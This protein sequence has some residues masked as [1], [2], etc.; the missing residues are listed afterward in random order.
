[1]K[2]PARLDDVP[3]DNY[4]PAHADLELTLAPLPPPSGL[5]RVLSP[6]SSTSL[7]RATYTTP[8]QHAAPNRA[9]HPR[10]LPIAGGAFPPSAPPPRPSPAPLG[11]AIPEARAPRPATVTTVSPRPINRAPI[12]QPEPEAARPVS[13][14]VP[15]GEGVLCMWGG[16][17]GGGGESIKCVCVTAVLVILTRRRLRW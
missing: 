13:G 1:V 15:S 3:L 8:S 7:P 4:L 11:D 6:P 16:S 10:P 12:G 5:Q 17:G 2:Y 14:E 9:P